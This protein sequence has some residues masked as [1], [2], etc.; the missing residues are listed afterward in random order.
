MINMII[1]IYKIGPVI[2]LENIVSILN[3]ILVG[4]GVYFAFIGL[5]AWKKQLKGK[6]NYDLARRLLKNIYAVRESI[7]F[8]RNPLI[9]TVEMETSLTKSGF[10][11]EDYSDRTKMHNA[12]YSIRWNKI[13]EAKAELDT[14]LI[15]VEVLW[16]KDYLYVFNQLNEKILKLYSTL[17]IFLNYEKDVPFDR[18]ILYDIGEKDLFN[19]EV[20]NVVKKI[21]EYVKPHLK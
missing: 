19:Q 18:N 7:R 20:N 21:E 13:M 4:F 5:D 1:E 8:V 12:V 16:G 15:E 2:T 14:L 10:K 17:T 6:D 11:P 9:S 3:L